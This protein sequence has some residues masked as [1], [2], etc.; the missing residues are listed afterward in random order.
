M[1]KAFLYDKREGTV[2][3]CLFN[4]INGSGHAQWVNISRDEGVRS[5]SDCYVDVRDLNILSTDDNPVPSKFIAKVLSLKL[6]KNCNQTRYKLENSISRMKDIG[7]EWK[8]G[9]IVMD[10]FVSIDE[11][12]TYSLVV[13]HL[14]IK[15]E[16]FKCVN[17]FKSL[18]EVFECIK[19]YLSALEFAN[20][21]VNLKFLRIEK[22][23]KKKIK[24]YH[25]A[26]FDNVEY[27]KI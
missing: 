21:P 17:D 16:F 23:L 10:F 27:I 8:K 24:D 1:T 25:L 20:I 22:V 9:A 26:G 15:R 2:Y 5:M 3:H 18:D 11:D 14:G 19:I 4:G 7:L 12:G 6:V 13:E